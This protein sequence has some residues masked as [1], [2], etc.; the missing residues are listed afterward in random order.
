M[1]NDAPPAFPSTLDIV[2]VMPG[3]WIRL[4]EEPYAG[5]IA[6]VLTDCSCLVERLSVPLRNLLDFD[7]CDIVDYSTPLRRSEYPPVLPT[8]EEVAPF[9][10]SRH[11]LLKHATFFGTSPSPTAGDRVV[12]VQGRFRRT[13]GYISILAHVPF[14]ERVV[15]FAKVVDVLPSVVN[16]QDAGVII[17]LGDLRRHAVEIPNPFR[18]SDRI[19]V[20]VGAEH[21]GCCGRVSEVVDDLVTVQVARTEATRCG[22]PGSSFEGRTTFQKKASFLVRDFWFHDL[23]EVSRGPLKDRKGFV[24]SSRRGGILSVLD[25]CGR[26]FL[27]QR[28]TP[29]DRHCFRPTRNISDQLGTTWS[30]WYD[31]RFFI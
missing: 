24:L 2:N 14:T 25:V 10:R 16:G 22:V 23:I 4:R 15:S 18:V 26:S 9:Q 12:A 7:V 11:L 20:A 31:P 1:P 17:P 13:T 6:L 29:D 3:E 27:S 28:Y 30:P 21:W 19:R 8:T 5:R